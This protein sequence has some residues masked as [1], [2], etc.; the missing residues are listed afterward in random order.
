MPVYHSF[1]VGTGAQGTVME[2]DFFGEGAG[3]PAFH[4][5][6]GHGYPV[7]G[8]SLDRNV[9]SD[10][11]EALL[12]EELA[13]ARDMFKLG[14]AV[15]IAVFQMR[16]RPRREFQRRRVDNRRP[17]YPEKLQVV[18]FGDVG[19]EV[20]DHVVVLVVQE[21]NALKACALAANCR[22]LWGFGGAGDPLMI[23]SMTLRS[24]PCH[25]SIHR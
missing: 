5:C 18:G 10:L 2:A 19:I 13:G 4:S 22:S 14:V 1:A 20:S 21:F 15:V 6:S 12:A 8:T 17:V 3:S 25:R 11:I 24:R 7:D 16:G 23:S 9:S